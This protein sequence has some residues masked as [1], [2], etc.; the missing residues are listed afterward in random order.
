MQER[1]LSKWQNML[2]EYQMTAIEEALL[3][4]IAQRKAS[5]VDAW[6]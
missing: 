5:M 3:D 1:A 2:R 4:F 6:Y